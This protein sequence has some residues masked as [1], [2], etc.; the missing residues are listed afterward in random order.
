MVTRLSSRSNEQKTTAVILLIGIEFASVIIC[1]WPGKA[2]LQAL[3]QNLGNSLAAGKYRIYYR[4]LLERRL[5]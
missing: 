1:F 3:L 4:E 2:L 5:Q